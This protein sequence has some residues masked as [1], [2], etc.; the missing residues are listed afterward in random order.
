MKGL[1]SMI[2]LSKWRL[3]EVRKELAAMEAMIDEIDGRIADLNAE[4]AAEQQAAAGGDMAGFAYGAYAKSVIARRDNLKSSRAETE[5]ARDAKKEEV[6]EAFQELKKYEMLDARAAE[7][8]AYEA[9][10]R[11]QTHLDEVGMQQHVRKGT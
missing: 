5:K 6:T 9:K 4:M 3:D 8:Q 2:R 1:Q 10:R 11:E 7:R